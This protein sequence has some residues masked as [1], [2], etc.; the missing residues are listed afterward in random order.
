MTAPLGATYR[1]QLGPSMGFDDAALLV[2]YLASLG[3]QCLYCSPVTEAVPG[4]TH[5]YD[6]TDPTK[7]RVELGGAGAF[8]RLAEA[9]AEAGL[10]C[11]VDIVPNHL[12]TWP[13]GPWWREVLRSGPDCEL[14]EVFDVDWAAGD[15]KVTLP[16]LD[17]PLAAAL[18]AGM[19]TPGVAADGEAVLRLGALTL[20]LRAGP[21]RPDDDLHDLL[22]V[23]HYRLIDWH[24]RRDRNYRR[25]FD[26]D[27]LVGIRVERPEVFD[28]THVLVA[29]L[30][31]EG[32]VT[33]LRVDHV[34]GLAD[35]AGYLRRLARL[36][37]GLPI[38]V[39]KILIG[40]ERIRSSWPVTG[41]TGYEAIDDIGGA[42]V[43]PGGLEQLA[44][45]AAAENEPTVELCT[46][47]TR[48]LVA[49]TTFTA[50]LERG[51]SALGVDPEA[52]AHVTTRLPIY[53]T[54]LDGGPVH[55]DD[56]AA[57]AVATAGRP[58]LRHVLTDP[59]R[60]AGAI[61][62]QQVSGAVM[63][64][65][66]EDTAWYRLPGRLA[67]CEVGGDPGRSREDGPRRLH[68]RA[69]ARAKS[70]GAGLVPS[71]THDT[72]RSGDARA[73]LYALSELAVP[74]EHGLAHYRSLVAAELRE[75]VRP[76][77][78]D[79]VIAQQS[80]LLAQTVLEVLPADPGANG[81]SAVDDRLAE[82]VR[83]AMIKCVREAKLYSSWDAPDERYERSVAALVEASMASGARLV[84]E[85]F[86]E[87]V[88]EVARI[89]ATISLSSVLLRSAL[90]GAPDC[91]QGDESWNLAL[92]DPDNRRPVDF[93]Y[94]RSRL[95]TL[96]TGKRPWSPHPGL[97]GDLR[98]NWRTGDVK[99]FV[100]AGC[101]HARRAAPGALSPTA[102]YF[103]VEAVGQAA[104]SVL[105]F[106]R[107]APGRTAEEEPGVLAVATR[108]VGR[109]D[110]APRDLPAGARSF[111]TTA[112]V[113]PIGSPGPFVDLL[114]GRTVKAN[115]GNIAVAEVLEELPVALLVE[116]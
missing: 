12:S 18:A 36:T 82:R 75:P 37:D 88:D 13:E 24:D 6:A 92:V 57:I 56:A 39:E 34:D 59:G 15:A 84:R 58:E 100:T 102:L 73:R 23:Q 50:E 14:A 60:I 17:R 101:L 81:A 32:L 91:Y 76:A 20:P 33:A 26:I 51:A 27:G 77:G 29:E 113:L 105:A 54:Y 38:V 110:A 11:L 98:V 2:D 16:V 31:R 109:L 21:L 87:L 70:A 99:M 48:S 5:G 96:P 40:D 90:P 7:L 115:A 89:G 53:R 44:D 8:R 3:V 104:P 47:T 79:S 78:G 107:R 85:A 103:A 42:L 67:F 35:P 112:L 80:R 45:A 68:A 64:K 4:S 19:I 86:G 116:S 30:V 52:L 69:T 97:G 63:A 10:G 108:L 61:A 41:T 94:L 66:V 55:P 93:D 83:G 46:A 28:R 72:K 71:S 106:G 43:D 111:G 74:F 62:W 25:F 9:L 65:G 1:L 114:T 22:A 95:A 49:R